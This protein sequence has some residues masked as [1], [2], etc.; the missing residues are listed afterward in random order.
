MPGPTRAVHPS[1]ESRRRR[2]KRF[3]YHSASPPLSCHWGEAHF[4]FHPESGQTHFVNESCAEVLAVV[5]QHPS[6]VPEIHAKLLARYGIDED[7]EL[8][9][10]IGSIVELLERLGVLAAVP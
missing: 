6:T 5:Q 1:P 10:S 3:A 7:E 8:L 2:V 4:V 9:A